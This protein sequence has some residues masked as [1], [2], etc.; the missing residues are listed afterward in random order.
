M[1]GY[2]RQTVSVNVDSGIVLFDR[3]DVSFGVERISHERSKAKPFSFHILC[4]W[5]SCWC[6][7]GFSPSDCQAPEQNTHGHRQPSQ[8]ATGDDVRECTG[9]KA[10]SSK[11]IILTLPASHGIISIFQKRDAFCHLLQLM[12]M[13]H[14]HQSEPDVISVFVGTWNMGKLLPPTRRGADATSFDFAVIPL[15]CVCRGI[16]PSTCS[17]DLDDVLRFGSHP[18]RGNRFAPTWHLCCWDS[19]KPSRGE[20]MGWAHK[21]HPPQLYSYWI[22]T[23]NSTFRSCFHPIFCLRSLN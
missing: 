12:K 3:K 1:L 8:H 18:W 9:E 19:G 10:W 5:V 22:Q 17:A 15:F 2:G 20:G 11:G 13:R 6:L 14:S 23:S 21:G 16:P 7:L 4:K